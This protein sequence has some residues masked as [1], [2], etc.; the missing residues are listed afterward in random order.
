MTQFANI[1][2]IIYNILPISY[3]EKYNDYS[4]AVKETTSITLL[5]LTYN[6]SKC[7]NIT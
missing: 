7:F 5:K 6:Y 3:L 4:L 2:F 1:L